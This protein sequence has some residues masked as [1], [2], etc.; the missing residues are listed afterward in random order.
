MREVGVLTIPER[1][2]RRDETVGIG[3]H[4]EANRVNETF[5]EFSG[6]TVEVTPLPCTMSAQAD[7]LATIRVHSDLEGR[8]TPAVREGPS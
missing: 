4:S 6:M 8:G 3:A 5:V 2:T 1:R 7:G